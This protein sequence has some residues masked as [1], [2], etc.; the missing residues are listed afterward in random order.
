M[1]FYF[2]NFLIIFRQQGNAG[3]ISSQFA[4]C[5]RSYGYIY[6][7]HLLPPYLGITHFKPLYPSYFKL[8][9]CWLPL[10]TPVTYLS[11]LLGVMILKEAHPSGQRKRCSNRSLTDLSLRC[12]VTR[13]NSGPSPFGASTSAVQKRVAF[14]SSNSNYF[15]YISPLRSFHSDK[16]NI[17]LSGV[18]KAGCGMG[19]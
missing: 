19:Q 6:R 18:R 9:G 12:R 14:L 15:G 1:Y 17:G 16:E 10:L 4:F 8:L 3:Q 7:R 11:K 5:Q 2:Y 13:P